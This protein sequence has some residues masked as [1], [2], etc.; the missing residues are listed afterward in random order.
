[1]TTLQFL[2]SPMLENLPA[3]DN[4]Q[5]NAISVLDLHTNSDGTGSPGTAFR[6]GPGGYNWGF[7]EH[8]RVQS[9]LIGTDF[10]NANT[11]NTSLKFTQDEIAIVQTIS[12]PGAGAARHFKYRN[13]QLLNQGNQ[14]V[15]QCCNYR[16]NLETHC[17]SN[18]SYRRNSVA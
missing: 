12:G 3:S 15:Y 7:S 5:F 2:L 1:M 18:R 17:E 9:K 10:I 8:D 4:N 6:Y 16:S 13:G 11:F 14:L